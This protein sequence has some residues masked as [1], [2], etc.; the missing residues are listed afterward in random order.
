M[1]LLATLEYDVASKSA[2]LVINPNAANS[3]RDEGPGDIGP[4]K[5][6][7]PDKPIEP[8]EPKSR[9]I[10]NELKVEDGGEPW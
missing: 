4:D 2:L 6:V 1:H 9:A 5:P 3:G 7:G 8:A 10:S